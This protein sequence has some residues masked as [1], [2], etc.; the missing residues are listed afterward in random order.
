MSSSNC[1]FLTC[2]WISQEAGKVV[3][4]SHLFHNFP[5]F[6]VIHTVKS[7]DRDNKAEVDVFLDH[8]GDNWGL[9]LST[10]LEETYISFLFFPKGQKRTLTTIL[11]KWLLINAV[12]LPICIWTVVILQL[13]GAPGKKAFKIQGV[14]E[15]NY[16]EVTNICLKV[17]RT[18]MPRANTE[19]V[20]KCWH[21]YSE[22]P[23]HW[24]KS[25]YRLIRS[26]NNGKKA[27]PTENS[28]QL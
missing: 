14:P 9:I 23:T 6:I 19:K 18:A 13:Q 28:W 10:F 16:Y 5:Q 12:G 3:W 26:K 8:A 21:R 17:V 25:S 20:T 11:V 1:C 7:F 4:Y 15:G 24:S 2:I 27:K 22:W